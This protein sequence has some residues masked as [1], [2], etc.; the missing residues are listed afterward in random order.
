MIEIKLFLA[1]KNMTGNEKKT[2]TKNP[3]F[4][5]KYSTFYIF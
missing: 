2:E 1:P 3:A 5:P 4:I